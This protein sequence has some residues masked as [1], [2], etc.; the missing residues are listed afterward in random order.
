M[1][2]AGFVTL[3]AVPVMAEETA[4]I[5]FQRSESSGQDGAIILVCGMKNGT[6]VTNGKMRILYD[7]DKLKLK[8]SKAGKHLENALCEIND[9]LTGN[10][11]EGEVVM[12]FASSKAIDPDG[13]LAELQFQP[14]QG[15][16]KEEELSVEVRV[17]KLSGDDGDVRAEGKI[18][19]F[20]TDGSETDP[21]D[22]DRQEIPGGDD[23]KNTDSGKVKTGDSTAVLPVMTAGAVALLAAVS[24]LAVKK[25]RKK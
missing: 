2:L 4:V 12:A 16:D 24:I 25:K 3:Q 7:G 23:S 21:K 9:C 5:S 15:V 20:R 19:T 13:E 6:Q 10:K 1:L 22:P 18:L 11:A 14:A 17:E 8:S